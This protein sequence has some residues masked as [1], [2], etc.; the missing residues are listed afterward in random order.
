MLRKELYFCPIVYSTVLRQVCH[1]TILKCLA[2]LRYI[3]LCLLYL[4]SS[5][6]EFMEYTNTHL[7]RAHTHTHTYSWLF[8]LLSW[9]LHR[10]WSTV[11]CPGTP[12]LTWSTSSSQ[13]LA[14][15]PPTPPSQPRPRRPTSTWAPRPARCPTMT[16][17]TPANPAPGRRGAP[18]PPHG[19]TQ[20]S[21][22]WP[23]HILELETPLGPQN[24]QG[25]DEHSN[26]AE[27]VTEH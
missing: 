23:R 11:C 6:N 17:P 21:I 20:V 1:N 12:P 27:T 3:F 15:P 10:V 5:D 4:G 25:G 8:M 14:C 22:T 2:I 9:L 26:G 24:W 18:R 7:T 13:T 19:P 16:R